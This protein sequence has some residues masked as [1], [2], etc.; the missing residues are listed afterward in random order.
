[1]MEDYLSMSSACEKAVLINNSHA[2]TY[3]L[4]AKACKGQDDSANAIA[5]LT[6]AIKLK[7]DYLEAYLNRSEILLENNDVAEAEQDAN[8]LMQQVPDNEDVLMLKARIEKAYQHNE[9][10][11]V[12]YTKAIDQNPFRT[13]AF[14]ERA[15]ARKAVNDLKGAQEDEQK[16]KEL[17]IQQQKGCNEQEVIN[18]QKESYKNVDPFGIF[19]F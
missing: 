6:K 19:G 17:S 1:M 2:E 9:N 3:Y 4:Y 11:I 16:A 7:D 12:F 18:K 10:A 15:E 13:D 8:V 14:S 5:M